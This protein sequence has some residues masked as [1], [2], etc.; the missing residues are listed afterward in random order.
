[1]AEGIFKK[2]LE[3]NR[4]EAEVSSCG[5]STFPG[6]PPAD[7]AVRAAAE[8]SADIS[9]HRSAQF[10]PFMIDEDTFFI[11]MTYS[12]AAVLLS[13]GVEK[14]KIAVLDI[15]DPYGGDDVVYRQCAALIYEK[16]KL[17][18]NQ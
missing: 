6:L 8:Y 16:L 1:M 13:A 4:I 10:S 17:L 11:C 5:V 18:L 9:A 2:L 12:H 15:P 14:E 7:E 3:E